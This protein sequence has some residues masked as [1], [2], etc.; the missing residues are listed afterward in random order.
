MRSASRLI[1]DM[2]RARSSG[3][4]A[5]PR[6][7]SSAYART[8]ASGVRSS[9]DASATNLR[10]LRSEASRALNDPSICASI[11]FSASPSRPTSV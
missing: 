8:A 5:A 11:A 6:V 10:S 2:E 1:P 7:N 4:S 3:R 9:C